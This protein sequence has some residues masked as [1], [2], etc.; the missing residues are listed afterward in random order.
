VLVQVATVRSQQ[1]AQGV[2]SRLQSSYARE[3]GGR[4]PT[5]DQTSVGSLGTLYRVQVGPFASAKDT[6]ALC[7][8]LKGD[9]LDCR[10][11]GQ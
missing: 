8:R 6:E 1:E 3:I 7:A 5:V 4:T 10:V 2:A 11:L 9:G